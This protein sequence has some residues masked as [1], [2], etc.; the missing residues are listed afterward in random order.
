V[1]ANDHYKYRHSKALKEHTVYDEGGD[2]VGMEEGAKTRKLGFR[3][4]SF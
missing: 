3:S 2:S 1:V 4:S